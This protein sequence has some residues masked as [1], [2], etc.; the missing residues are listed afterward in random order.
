MN[1]MEARKIANDSGEV[2]ATIIR[3]PGGI[4]FQLYHVVKELGLDE[5]KEN[6]RLLERGFIPL[7]E[8]RLEQKIQRRL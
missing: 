4:H 3:I 6:P 8:L 5:Q 1:L 2:E 7:S